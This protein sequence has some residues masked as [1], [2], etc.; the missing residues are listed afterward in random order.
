LLLSLAA[1]TAAV[2]AVHVDPN[3]PAGV[4]YSAPLD[5]ARVEAGGVGGEAG[6]PGSTEQA[7]LFG[8]GISR[9]KE[10]GASDSRPGGDHS[11]GNAGSSISAGDGDDAVRL[12]AG[13]TV[14]VLAGGAVLAL[15]IRRF[16]RA[17]P[18]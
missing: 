10:S 1:P 7:P 9:G 12:V 15:A 13:I 6:A 11:A 18:Q 3:A 17:A 5:R 4:Q 2:G 8:K 14:A 16:G